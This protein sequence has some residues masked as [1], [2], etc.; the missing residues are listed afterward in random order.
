[1]QSS[2]TQRNAFAQ[3]FTA[4]IYAAVTGKIDVRGMVEQKAYEETVA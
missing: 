4:L 1:M 3:T 2:L